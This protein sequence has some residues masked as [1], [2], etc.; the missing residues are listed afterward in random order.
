MRIGLEH[1]D[2][3][4]EIVYGVSNN[5]RSW[6]DNSNAYRLGY[7]PEDNSEPYAEAVLVGEPSNPDP[8]AERYQGGTLPAGGYTAKTPPA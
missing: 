1:P 4:Y 8:I 2:V 6:Y 5:Q 3:R 7:K